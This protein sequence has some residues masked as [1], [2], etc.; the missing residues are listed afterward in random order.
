MAN[1]WSIIFS[2]RSISDVSAPPKVEP[3]ALAPPLATPLDTEILFHGFQ[4]MNE[5]IAIVLVMC[6]A[7]KGWHPT[8]WIGTLQ[9]DYKYGI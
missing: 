4:A 1:G 8:V 3:G 2:S 9:S 6:I 7:S 5:Y